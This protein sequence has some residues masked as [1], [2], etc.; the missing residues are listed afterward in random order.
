VLRRRY[1]AQAQ[2]AGKTERRQKADASDR[3]RRS[4]AEGVSG[5]VEVEELTDIEVGSFSV[6][7][8]QWGS[9]CKMLVNKNKVGRE[10]MAVCTS[11]L[12]FNML[13]NKLLNFL[14]ST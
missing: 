9:G 11:F 13:I 5:G 12:G 3:R 10:Q 6:G 2:T 4:A 8:W 14:R 1:Y 7:S